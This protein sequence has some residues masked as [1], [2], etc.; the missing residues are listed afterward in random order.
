MA[1][2]LGIGYDVSLTLCVVLL[3]IGFFWKDRRSHL[4]RALGWSVFGVF[5]F[6]H[7]PAYADQQDALNALGAAVALPIFLFVAYHEWLSYR[8]REEDE[9]LPVACGAPLFASA[10]YFPLAPV[11]G[12]PA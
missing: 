12:H 1:T 5:W 11:P 2:S 8:W 10:V 9:P 4:V 6:L 7:V 3:G